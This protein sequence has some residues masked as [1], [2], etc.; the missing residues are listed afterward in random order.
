MLTLL[1]KLQ[2]NHIDK[3]NKEAEAAK[4]GSDKDADKS[5][6]NGKGRKPNFFERKRFLN[7]ENNEDNDADKTDVK[8]LDAKKAAD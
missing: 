1:K 3:K 2:Q 4:K 8:P 6:D 5:L 7:Y